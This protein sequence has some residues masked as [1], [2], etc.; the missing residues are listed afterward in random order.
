M[1]TK[2]KSKKSATKRKSRT[3]ARLYSAAVAAF[4]GHRT[5]QEARR[6][7]KGFVQL[8]GRAA[9][10]KT[11]DDTVRILTTETKRLLKPAKLRRAKK[12]TT[13]RA[14]K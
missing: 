11:F 2:T 13:N 5:P 8:V 1:T 7:A 6:I 14:K 9:R 3:A 4:R 10:A 12:T